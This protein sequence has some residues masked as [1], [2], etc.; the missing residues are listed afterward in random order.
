MKPAARRMMLTV[1]A[2]GCLW[3]VAEATSP[4]RTVERELGTLVRIVREW[5][6]RGLPDEDA[7]FKAL[8]GVAPPADQ[9]RALSVLDRLTGSA[10]ERRFYF[11]PAGA[12]PGHGAA[13]S[14]LAVT[15]SGGWGRALAFCADTTPLVC[16]RRDGFEPRV[17]AGRC[18][19]PR[20]EVFARGEQVQQAD[21]LFSQR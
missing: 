8:V 1:A 14:S 16:V 9:R 19:D 18:A 7:F 10:F 4:D 6:Q 12:R 11:G 3:A 13:T 15:S 21:E 17:K 20:C 5:S 2:W